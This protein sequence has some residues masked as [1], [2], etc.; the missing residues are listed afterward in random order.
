MS[1]MRRFLLISSVLLLACHFSLGQS[2]YDGAITGTVT[3]ASGRAASPATVIIRNE[4]TG[5]SI[6]VQAGESGDYRVPGLSPGQYG[7]SIEA[8][9]LERFQ[10]S[11]VTIAVGETTTLNAVL[12][13]QQVDTSVVVSG[14]APAIDTESAA[15]A[16]VV[17]ERQ[18]SN[19]PIN[20]RRW[21][22]FVLL[23]P[24]TQRDPTFGLVSFRGISGLQNN[25]TIDGADNNDAFWSEERGRALRIGYSSPQAAVEEFQVNTANFSSEYGRAAGGVVNTVTRS[26]S[27]ALHGE[28]YVFDRDNRWGAT[29]PFTVLSQSV[30][31]VY[32]TNPFKPVDRR[33]QAGLGIGG[34]LLRDRLFF[35]FAFDFYQRNY[36]AVAVPGSPATFFASATPGQLA[37]LA[38]RLNTTPA[39]AQQ[40]YNEGL[41]GLSSLLGQAARNGTQTIYFPKLDWQVSAKHH[42][43]FEVNRMM[44]AAPGADIPGA[45]Y[46]DGTHTSGADYVKVLWGLWR[47]DSTFS[48]SLLN[49][50]RFQYGKDLESEPVP[51]QAAYEKTIASPQLGNTP[52]V[53]VAG[54][55]GFSFGPWIYLPRT[56]YPDERR[57]QFADT[58]TK[59]WGHHTTSAGLDYNYVSDYSSNL[60]YAYGNYT[61]TSVLNYLS[62]YYGFKNGIG[63]RCDSTG[64]AVGTMPCYTSFLQGLGP[65][66]FQIATSD[67]AG[68][69][70]DTWKPTSNLTLTL[71]LRYEFQSFPPPIS[72]IRNSAL[73]TT[74][75]TPVNGGNFGPRLG[76]SWDPMKNQ[77]TVLHAGYGLYYGRVPNCNLFAARIAT[78]SSNAQTTYLSRASTA[79]APVFPNAFEARPA[80][81]A[82]KPSAALL[83]SDLKVPQLNEV[84]RRARPA[85]GPA[86]C[87]DH[88]G[89]WAHSAGGCPRQRT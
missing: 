59:Q 20:G 85:T 52:S 68:F 58:L 89:T 29:N 17:N 42:S 2:A 82:T 6:T 46:P 78:G 61:Y 7:V 76:V 66:A 22:D 10:A 35:F 71:G 43:T 62:D 19:L 47:F 16:S 27:N 28:A 15:T 5:R 72:S 37:L 87:S 4:G 12:G 75:G 44:W 57:T 8:T 25:N 53:S 9:G 65:Q 63:G 54:T 36:P 79:G 56:A 77:T 74:A 26:G 1:V 32:T 3:D 33:K 73:P 23:T 39:D 69:V 67:Y 13:I 41:T 49:Q 86:Y 38:S 80:A 83:A 45:T 40:L 60:N 24:G 14:A 11:H 21:S 88:S 84:G 64:N 48:P 81:S 18:I 50:A 70:N 55:N 30:N 31:G 51:T 34:P